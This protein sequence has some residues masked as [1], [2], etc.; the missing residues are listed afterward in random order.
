MQIR[1]ANLIVLG[2]GF[3]DIVDG[4]QALL[5]AA[6]SRDADT[7]RFQLNKAAK[8]IMTR[9]EARE[10]LAMLDIELGKQTRNKMTFF[11][12]INALYEA[13]L[14]RP[15]S[16]L[17]FTLYSNAKAAQL[18]PLLNAIAPYLRMR[19][20]V[21]TNDPDPEPSSGEKK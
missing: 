16:T 18:D 14:V 4:D 1:D 17:I 20:G 7:K 10:Q 19:N 8:H 21:F 11:N 3:L 6:V 2:H 5:K 12:G 13:F 9:D 15:T